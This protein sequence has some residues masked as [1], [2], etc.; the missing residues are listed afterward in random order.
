MA[1]AFYKS[2]THAYTGRQGQ[3][4]V[5]VKPRYHSWE[6]VRAKSETCMY[7]PECY[8]VPKFPLFAR[9]PERSKYLGRCEGHA[10]LRGACEARG[11]IILQTA[12]AFGAICN[13]AV[14]K[15][16]PSCTGQVPCS[17]AKPRIVR[18]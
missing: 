1:Y 15:Y 18:R 3:R 9:V 12:C 10:E 4:A 11:D 5:R 7:A 2:D 14:S 16:Q 6:C 13:R 8:G 17:D